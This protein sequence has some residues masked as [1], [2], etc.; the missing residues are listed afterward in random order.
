MNGKEEFKGKIGRTVEDSEPWWPAPKRLND[1]SPNVVVILLDDTGFSHFGCYG[2]SI[3]TPNIDKLAASGLRYTNFHTTALC[4]PT[5]ACLLTGR[6]HHAVGMRAVSNM[7]SGFPNLRGSITKNAATLGEILQEEGYITFMTGKWHL[8]QM[9]EASMAGPFDNWPLKRGFDRFY[10]FMQGETD[11]FYPELT[12]DNHPIDPPYG[13][14]EGYHVSEDLVDRSMEFICD[15]KSVRPGKPFFLYLAFGATHA[16]HQSPLEYRQKYR[17]KFDAGWDVTREKWYK[18]QLELGVIPPGTDL[19]PRNNGVKAWDELSE[20]HKRFA[21]RLQEAFAAFLDHTDHQIGRLVSF[22]EEIGEIENTLI[23]VTSDNGASQEGGHAGIMEEM[24]YFNA[25]S[26]DI[27]AIQ[28]R[29]DDIGGPNSHSNYPWGWAQVGNTP[30]KWYKQNT[31]GGGIRDP[32]IMHWPKRIKDKGGIRNQFHHVSDIMPTILE[33][34]EIEPAPSYKGYDQMPISGTSMVYT[35]DAPEEKTR[36]YTQYFEMFGHR[37]IVHD[38]WKAV[39]HHTKG[40]SFDMKE[41]ELYHLD[42]DFSECHNLAS[43]N[44]EKLRELVDLWWNEAGR[45][46]VLPLDDRNIE[47]FRGERQPG[48]VHFNRHYVYYPPINHLPAGVAPLTAA[49]S[50][51]IDVEIER[52]SEND[53]GVLVA[54]GTMNGGLSFYIKDSHLVFDFNLF[55]DHQVVRSDIPVP[56][57]K[58]TVRAHFERQKRKGTLTISINGKECGSV[59]IP[60]LLYIIS[61]TGTDIG[62][63]SLSPV[64]NDYKGPFEFTG[65][66]YRVVIDL[67][68]YTGRRT[69]HDRLGGM[70]ARKKEEKKEAEANHRTEMY[71]Q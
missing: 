34:L 5:R 49:R 33:L 28:D 36:K 39:T 53:N 41:W 67:P 24:K 61:S 52:T 43:E 2:S 69:R 35:F 11:Q 13:P 54:V 17:G 31:H 18:K 47:L 65:K 45:H 26:E 51:I 10:G 20:N 70:S 71:K 9:E 58:S 38:G 7:N 21:C 32:L 42:E 29:L 4:S 23:V 68:K 1:G 6:N 14:E 3:D 22:L 37:G 48:S 15:L 8:T 44:P 46:G 55:M 66:I 50:W 63:D 60:Y 57:G 40:Q 30:L 56:T 62:R 16:P 25:R 59:P 12:Y 64:T 27:N 19:A